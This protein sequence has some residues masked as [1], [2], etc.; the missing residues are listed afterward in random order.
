LNKLFLHLGAPKTGSTAL[1]KEVFENIGGVDSGLVYLGKYGVDNSRVFSDVC[2][3]INKSSKFDFEKKSLDIRERLEREV[4]ANGGVGL[5]SDESF[6]VTSYTAFGKISVEEKIDRM[7]V[8]FGGFSLYIILGVR[9]QSRAVCSLYKELYHS[10]AGIA[11]IKFPPAIGREWE[12]V[13]ATYDYNFLVKKF[14]KSKNFGDIHFYLFEEFERYQ[15]GV[16]YRVL[17]FMGVEEFELKDV[18]VVNDKKNI[19]G[20]TVLPKLSLKRRL[21]LFLLK[22]SWVSRFLRIRPWGPFVSKVWVSIGARLERVDVGPSIA[23]PD[24]DVA[25]RTAS[26]E[27]YMC[28]NMEIIKDYP[29]LKNGM[30]KHG[31]FVGED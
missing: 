1:Q 3:L 15:K 31:Y 28:S 8:I 16:V 12:D 26:K 23:L 11:K 7:L 21:E 29:S 17:Q 5:I 22:A 20:K 4:A 18:P 2:A 30:A 13:F 19:G 24:F 9:E 6:I 25:F 14:S 10:Y 27:R